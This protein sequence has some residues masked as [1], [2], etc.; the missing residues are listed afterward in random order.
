MLPLLY[1]KDSTL[2]LKLFSLDT[3]KKHG[4]TASGKIVSSVLLKKNKGNLIARTLLDI[5][6]WL[7]PT[8]GKTPPSSNRSIVLLSIIIV[9]SPVRCL[10][11]SF[12]QDS[13][14]TVV[15][16]NKLCRDDNCSS[17]GSEK[18][19]GFKKKFKLFEETNLP[20]LDTSFR[21]FVCI[22][23]PFSFIFCSNW[24]YEI[25]VVKISF[26]L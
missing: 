20:V 26:A 8:A 25:L 22:K 21:L 18:F 13:T 6:V 12:P 15:R 16:F 7:N 9:F 3:N 1:F 2:K 17:N 24:L 19:K 10:L 4:I 11:F 5:K 23:N 14:A